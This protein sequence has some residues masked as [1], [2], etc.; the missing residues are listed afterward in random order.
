MKKVNINFGL[1]LYNKYYYNHYYFIVKMF[2]FYLFL[3]SNFFQVFFST[4]F[5]F[6]IIILIKI[7]LN[8]EL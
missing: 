7:Y 2:I 8:L 4:N 3:I 5:N 6:Y 1:D